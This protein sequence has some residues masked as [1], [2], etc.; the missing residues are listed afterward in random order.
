[1]KEEIKIFLEVDENGNTTYWKIWDRAKEVPRG[2]VIAMSAYI[3]RTERSQINDLM[4]H[5]KL[6]KNKNKKISKQAE[7]EE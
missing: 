7:G 6:Q 1:M 3:K 5:L 2:K 4:F